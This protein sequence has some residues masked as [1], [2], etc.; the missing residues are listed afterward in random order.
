MKGLAYG[1]E[2]NS[3]KFFPGKETLLPSPFS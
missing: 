3:P 2:E 1:S